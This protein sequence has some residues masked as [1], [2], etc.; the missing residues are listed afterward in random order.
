MRSLCQKP[1]RSKAF[2]RDDEDMDFWLQ[3]MFL[4]G[5]PLLLAITN[6]AWIIYRIF[7]IPKEAKMIIKAS[8][9]K[10]PIACLGSDDGYADLEVLPHA[11]AGGSVSTSKKPEEHWI[12]FLARSVE[13]EEEKTTNQK[14]GHLINKLASRK[15]FLRSAKVPIW[16]GYSGKA[17][18]TSL[19]ALIAQD[20]IS[21]IEKLGKLNPKV[22]VDLNQIKSLFPKPWDETQIRANEIDAKTEGML[23]GKKFFG[24]EGLKYFVLPGM[25]IIAIIILAIIFMV[26][27]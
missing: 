14:I 4:F 12:G 3:L 15:L 10:K 16:F 5:F 20:V 18:L 6:V 7:F 24:M 13:D 2:F 23:E 21:E 1:N 22:V 19:Y 26:L 11:G 8:R 9:K 25:I 27:G 17:I